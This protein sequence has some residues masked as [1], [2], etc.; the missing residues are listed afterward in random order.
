V[1]GIGNVRSIHLLRWARTVSA[2]GHDVHL[3]SDREP[4]E[5]DPPASFH[6]IQSLGIA[7]RIPFARRAAIAPAL[8]R[9]A[10]RLDAD[11]VHAHYLLP[12][13][14]WAARSGARP[15]VMSPW[16][17]D[18]LVPGRPEGRR[19][20]EEAVRAADVVVVNSKALEQAS[21]DLGAP[22]EQI[23]NVFWH[24]DLDGF[25]PERADPALRSSLGWPDD[26]LVILSLRN[27]R[28]D[29][30]IDTL[31]TAFNDVAEDEPRARLLLAGDSGPLRP[32]LETMAHDLKL[33]DRVAF[34]RVAARDLPPLVA[35]ADVVVSIANSDST[36][37]SL[38]EAM[39]S[40]RAVVC[41]DAASID[42]WV[43]PGEG[44][45]IV[46]VR[47]KAATAEA[48]LGLLRDD[49]RRRTYGERNRRVVR[50]TVGDPGPELDRLYRELVTA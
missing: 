35:A 11:L 16:G 14:Y 4:R 25:A 50:E 19:R 20:A 27:F 24:L 7:T 28:P 41:A 36:P 22:A 21:L 43:G 17:S 10:K 31:L 42:E 2:A 32:S 37:P 1:L 5:D 8:G 39:A 33:E 29:T 38:L 40:G 15:L 18:A 46:P 13:G 26:A 9:L 6:S 44:A 30:N 23:R 34:H 45:E 12:Y 48:I 49:T 3:A 47:D